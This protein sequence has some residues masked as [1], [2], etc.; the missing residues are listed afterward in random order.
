MR[1]WKALTGRQRTRPQPLT[2]EGLLTKPRPFK[3]KD[4]FS[5][6]MSEQD[7]AFNKLMEQQ[8]AQFDQL[9]KE[10]EDAFGKDMD[11]AFDSF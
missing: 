1:C 2:E 8:N 9:M 4:L 11:Q 10:Q 6:F 7:S 5:L 3:D